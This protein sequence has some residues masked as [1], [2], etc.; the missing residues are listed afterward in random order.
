MPAEAEKFVGREIIFTM[1]DPDQKKRVAIVDI[2]QRLGSFCSHF[3]IGSIF[4][5][6]D[7]LD[8]DKK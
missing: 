2:A 3:S 1:K 6:V 8:L 4:Y 5:L 7:I